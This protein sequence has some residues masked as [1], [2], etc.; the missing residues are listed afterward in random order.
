MRVVIY[1]LKPDESIARVRKTGEPSQSAACARVRARARMRREWL[2]ILR[3]QL[4]SSCSERPDSMRAARTTTW[5]KYS[6]NP[7]L[8]SRRD[9]C[10]SADVFHAV[11]SFHAPG[12]I[13]TVPSAFLLP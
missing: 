12:A 9:A 7:S 10:F 5:N 13:T 2:T 1:E 11:I 6:S 3:A 4:L 8:I